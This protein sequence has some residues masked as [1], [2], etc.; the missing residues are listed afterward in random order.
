MAL[1]KTSSGR[2]LY[3]ECHGDPHP[4]NRPPLLLVSGMAGSCAGWLPLQMPHFSAER[5]VVIFDHR[6]VGASEDDGKIFS[7]ADL[8]QDAKSLL[9]HLGIEK[10]DV[11]GAFMGGMT[12]QELAL[13]APDRVAK[14]V[15]VGTYARA[16]NKR[17]M[18]LKHWAQLAQI[19]LSNE[20]FIYN[21]LLWTL[22]DDTIDQDDLI[23]AMTDFYR[24]KNAPVSADLFVRQCKA[25]ENHD[26]TDRLG[27][28]PHSTLILSGR[29]D[30]LTPPKFHRELAKLIPQS[31]HVT[32]SYGGHLVMVESAM[33]FN[34]MVSQ[35]L[36]EED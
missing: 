3:Y 12:A 4:G 24:D 36:D 23:Q 5:P 31:R 34:Q 8:A 2:D 22:H 11:L 33:Q 27:E 6:G 7:T 15:L 16:D 26:T 18:L 28:L 10:V 25:C 13:T 29:Q 19:G 32:L 14:L 35:F 9:D 1:M 30:I 20:T 17:L 21:R